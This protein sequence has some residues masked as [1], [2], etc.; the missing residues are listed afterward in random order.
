MA[1][2]YAAG[3]ANRDQRPLRDVDIRSAHFEMNIRPVSGL[4]T[5]CERES[6]ANRLLPRPSK[7]TPV[8]DISNIALDIWSRA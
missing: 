2:C 5:I 1:V 3:H 7:R 6:V 8:S 4:M